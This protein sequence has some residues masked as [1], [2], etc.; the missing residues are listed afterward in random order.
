MEYENLYIK[1]INYDPIHTIVLKNG[2]I[3]VRSG[4]K[5]GRCPKDKR[6]VYDE[7]TKNIDWNNVNIKM[8]HIFYSK[9]KENI[10][11]Y[12]DENSSNIYLVYGKA[13]WENSKCILIYCS[14][15]YHAIF[16]KN[17]LVDSEVYISNIDVINSIHKIDFTIYAF[18]NLKL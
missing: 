3:S 7:F 6:I 11:E 13:G 9:I 10:M 1:C 5:T 18:G 16:M 14:N 8:S 2:A 15:P 17:M 4:D 12:L